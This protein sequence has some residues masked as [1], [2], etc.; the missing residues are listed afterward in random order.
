M[1]AASSNPALLRYF[2]R[3]EAEH[4]LTRAGF[5][6]TAL[7]G[8]FDRSAFTDDSPEMI[9]TAARTENTCGLR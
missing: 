4:L 5:E 9:F 3:Y 6:V 8:S 1:T 7:Y 2:F